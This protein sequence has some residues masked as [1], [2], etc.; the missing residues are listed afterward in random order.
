MIDNKRG[1]HSEQH[2]QVQIEQEHNRP[3][4]LSETDTENKEHWMKFLELKRDSD[5]HQMSPR[6]FDFGFSRCITNLYISVIWIVIVVFTILG[7]GIAVL[8]GL[9]VMSQNNVTGWLVILLATLIAGLYLLVVRLVLEVLI[10]IETHLRT[11]RDKY[12]NEGGQGA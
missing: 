5:T 3:S 8:F 2:L 1:S 9:Q 4:T 10:R 6:L 12:A 11:I 7:Y